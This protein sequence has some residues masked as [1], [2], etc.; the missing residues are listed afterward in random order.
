[1]G[2][3]CEK[4]LVRGRFPN[5]LIQFKRNPGESEP[6]HS[7]RV[8]SVPAWNIQKSPPNHLNSCFIACSQISMTL[9]TQW[10]NIRKKVQFREATFFFQFKFC[11]TKKW[12]ILNQKVVKNII[13]FD[14]FSH[15]Y[16]KKWLIYYIF[17]APFG[18][19]MAYC[20]LFNM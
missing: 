18:L 4:E 17:L 7:T 11:V 12:A 19:K 16:R 15:Y 1:M 5:L 20:V 8:R 10:A 13:H 9:V 6:S 14:F 2:P 3:F